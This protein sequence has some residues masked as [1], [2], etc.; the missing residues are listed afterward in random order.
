MIDERVQMYYYLFGIIENIDNNNSMYDYKQT[1]HFPSN[2]RHT[3]T[4]Y[5]STLSRF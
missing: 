5:V 1:R 2:N 4:R 3:K